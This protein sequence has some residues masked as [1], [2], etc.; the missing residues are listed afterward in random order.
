MK[1][2][3]LN[4]LAYDLKTAARLAGGVCV[5]HLV[6]L[7]KRGDLRLTHVGR[8]RV[9]MHEELIRYLRDNAAPASRGCDGGP[10][11]DEPGAKPQAAAAR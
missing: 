7:S 11:R 5:K 9:V 2:A 6:N 10:N 3:E 4:P 8:R 1:D